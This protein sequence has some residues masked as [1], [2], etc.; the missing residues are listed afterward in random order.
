MRAE[1]GDPK[2]KYGCAT[3]PTDGFINNGRAA[4]CYQAAVDSTTRTISSVTGK[5]MSCTFLKSE[6]N[7]CYIKDN[8]TNTY[9]WKG[10][11]VT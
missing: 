4:T 11:N 1:Q 9:I 8:N 6:L 5:Y 10:N 7:N 2:Y 3:S